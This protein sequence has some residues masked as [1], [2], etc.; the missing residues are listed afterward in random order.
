MAETHTEK[1]IYTESGDG[2]LLEGALFTPHD[3]GRAKLPVVW[4]HGFTGRFYEPHAVAIARR[5]AERGHVFLSGNNR[6]HH[7]GASITNLRGG[8]DLL[9]GGWWE[10]LEDSA[11]D[12]SAWVAFAVA[13]GFPR[14]V[15]AGHSLGAVKLV[16][17][18][19]STQDERVA[20]AVSASGPAFIGRRMRA[21]TEHIALAERMVAEGRGRDLLPPDPTGRITSAQTFAARARLNLDVFG[22]DRDDAPIGAIRCPLLF[23]LGS[24]EPEIATRAE[25]PLLE[26]NARSSSG[27]ETLYVEGADHVYHNCE[28]AVANGIGDWLE[29]LG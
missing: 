5:L 21:A 9:G 1:L 19:A 15:L 14:V 26:R 18:L 7:L 4:M 17:Y 24:E 16:Q 22:L 23:V 28:L 6:G 3:G 8:E 25:I 12:Y 11:F 2:Y 27:V 29:R 10:T 13:L 20:A